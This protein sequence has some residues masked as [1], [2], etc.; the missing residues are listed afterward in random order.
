MNQG[1]LNITF[2]EDQ[3]DDEWGHAL[4]AACCLQKLAQLL[5]NEVIVE[6]VAFVT[7]HIT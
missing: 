2:E 3:D 1:L 5:K 7:Q 4:S 6:V